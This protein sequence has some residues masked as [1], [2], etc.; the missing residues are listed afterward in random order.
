MISSAAFRLGKTTIIDDYAISS[1]ATQQLVDMGMQSMVILPIRGRG[2][3]P[4]L[5]TMVSEERNYFSRDLV[6]RL[7]TVV[8]G[9][10]II[11]DNSILQAESQQAHLQLEKLTEELI[12]S[13]QTI[14]QSN[15]S[16]EERVRIRTQELES[17]NERAMRSERLAMIGQLL[18]GIAHDL[19]NPLGAIKNAVY[20]IKRKPG[21]EQTIADREKISSFLN[22]IDDE[23]DRS[24]DVI[25]NL[26]SFG[27]AKPFSLSDIEV[28]DVI[29]EAANGI[30]IQENIDLSLTI[31]PDLPS[32]SGNSIQLTRILQNL[33]GNAQEAMQT[34]VHCRLLQKRKNILLKLLYRTQEK[35]STLKT[36]KKFRFIIYRQ[37]VRDRIR[38]CDMP[39]YRRQA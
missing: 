8:D 24:N 30:V 16:L 13:N 32:I 4:G 14:V 11:I 36:S 33:L 17:A 38:A 31:D 19:R 3:I 12:A 18:G 22:V 28:H 6:G 1:G 23:I 35:V 39:G 27:S 21:E 5:V 37:T 9:L 10:G 20:F 15:E 34:G 2:R 7:N 29:N 26:L 25:S